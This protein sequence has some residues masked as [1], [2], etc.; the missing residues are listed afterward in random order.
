MR[1]IIPPRSDVSPRWYEYYPGITSEIFFHRT[2][3]IPPGLYAKALIRRLI[4]YRDIYV[5]GK[6]YKNG[7]T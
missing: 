6:V 5:S 3:F 1:K 4:F 7:A 2:Q